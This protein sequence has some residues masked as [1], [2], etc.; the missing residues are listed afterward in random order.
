MS[1]PRRP[2]TELDPA[3]GRPLLRTAHSPPK[4]AT[5]SR[6]SAD[7]FPASPRTVRQ[8]AKEPDAQGVCRAHIVGAQEG[9]AEDL[10]EGGGLMRAKPQAVVA[11]C[12][13]LNEL[14]IAGGAIVLSTS[15]KSQ[16]AHVVRQRRHTPRRC[17]MAPANLECRWAA[18]I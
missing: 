12:L 18:S 14:L 15:T 2:V 5:G 9:K 11:A 10:D 3:R 4:T 8:S 17:S 1:P 7:V 13:D 6:T 16:N